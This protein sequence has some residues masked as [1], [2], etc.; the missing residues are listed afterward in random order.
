[1]SSFLQSLKINNL[2]SFGPDSPTM[3][4]GPLNVIIGPNGSGKSNLFDVMA[5]LKNAP[6][7]S[8]IDVPI[9]ESGCPLK[10]WLWKSKEGELSAANI[11]A[12]VSTE[13]MPI[14]Y[15]I[16]FHDQDNKFAITKETIKTDQGISFF[17][18]PSVHDFTVRHG[19]LL[20]FCDRKILEENKLVDFYRGIYIYNNWT[21]GRKSPLRLLQNAHLPDKWL[22]ENGDNFGVVLRRIK[23]HPET[24]Q[25]YLD[26][27][28]QL[29][30]GVDDF[31]IAEYDDGTLRVYLMEGERR[32]HA[33]RLSDGTLRYMMLL[34]VLCDPEPSPLIC[35]EEP[36]MGLHPDLI[37]VMGDALKYASERTQVIVTTHS[38]RL[39][40]C[41]NDSPEAIQVCEKH[42][43]STIIE[44]LDPEYLKPWLEKYRLGELWTRG[45]IGGNRW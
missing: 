9:Y 42:D 6:G 19:S 40:D 23:N 29:Y 28:K 26:Y 22:N 30:E 20:Y 24:Y 8:S 15:D 41:F 2:L 16:T 10:E 12:I 45:G 38:I 27:L 36:E 43:G 44:R 33:A 35:I 11:E 32:I 17:P 37:M 31:V 1:M 13:E 21:F 7:P 39:V 5:L 34:A 4:F 14:Y 3:E 25:C 18:D